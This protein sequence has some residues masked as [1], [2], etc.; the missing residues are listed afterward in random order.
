VLYLTVADDLRR[1]IDRG[2]LR[3]G[4]M[5]GS[6]HKLARSRNISRMTVRRA[7]ELLVNEGVIERR[8]G[9]GHLA[10]HYVYFTLVAEGIG[11]F[12]G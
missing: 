1:Q 6:E 11:R 7:S 12:T 8:P 4:D 10:G 5:F 9:K 3:P 2:D